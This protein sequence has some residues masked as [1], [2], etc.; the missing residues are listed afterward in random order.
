[1]DRNKYPPGL[2]AAKV[3]EI[4]D[5]Y[6]H[7]TDDEI[8]NEIEVAYKEHDDQTVLS[9]E[10][11]LRVI[12]DG[13]RD[14]PPSKLAEIADFV[15]FLRRR[16]SPSTSPLNE[17]DEALKQAELQQVQGQTKLGGV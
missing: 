14:L 13:L 3:T 2:D 10:V 4:I 5:Y 6:E 15:Y 17:L 16:L 12:N 1:M 7:Q 9:V 11:Y 8:S